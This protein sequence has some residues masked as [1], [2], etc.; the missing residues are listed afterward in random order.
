[1][2][3][4][5]RFRPSTESDLD[6]FVQIKQ[7]YTTKYHVDTALFTV[8]SRSDTVRELYEA[9]AKTPVATIA[10]M[11]RIMGNIAGNSTEAFICTPVLS[12]QRRN[13]R[14]N[15]VDMDIEVSLP[16]A[17]QD[18]RKWTS[19]EAIGDVTTGVAC[20][21][22]IACNSIT[23]NSVLPN[24]TE[25]CTTPS[26]LTDVPTTSNIADETDIDAITTLA[27][28]V[29]S[30]SGSGDDRVDHLLP[31]PA[32]QC[33]ILASKFPAETIKID[34]SGRAFDRMSSTRKSLVCYT[35]TR[36]K[37]D[38]AKPEEDTVRRRSRLRRPRG[39]RRNTIASSDQREIAEV[40]NKGE[41]DSG[42][43]VDEH[44]VCDFGELMPAIRSKSGDLLRKEPSFSVEFAKSFNKMS[45]FN[46]LK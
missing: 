14:A 24:I 44:P 25:T 42:T 45:H 29:A 20:S 36:P 8:D 34:T 22:K 35:T 9:A 12:R 21:V 43:A 26:D 1:M 17:V 10:E 31:S 7:H 2:V 32:E 28:T 13:A 19:S 33:R 18:L 41:P 46:S 38:D 15:N 6:T 11:D 40:I 39:K 4:V 37:K 30:N 5:A 3:Y 23:N 27:E 16:T